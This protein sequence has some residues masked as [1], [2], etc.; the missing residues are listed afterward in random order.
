M[1]KS[2]KIAAF[3]VLAV[4]L[5]AGILNAVLILHSLSSLLL[6][7]G[8]DVIPITLLIACVIFDKQKKK[9]GK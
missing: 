2:G 6:C 7:I 4:F 5:V 8:L 1:T 9:E 3:S